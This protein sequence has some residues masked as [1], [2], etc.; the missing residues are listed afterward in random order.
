MTKTVPAVKA[1]QQLGSL[2]NEVDLKGTS[3]VIERDG[4]AKAVMISVTQFE[5]LQRRRERARSEIQ[6]QAERN[7]ALLAS[8]GKSFEE[9]EAE[10]TNTIRKDCKNV[11]PSSEKA[12]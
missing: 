7:E 4:K 1:R 12:A 6:A 8:E 5:A 11:S 9:F 10:I 3:I 2:L